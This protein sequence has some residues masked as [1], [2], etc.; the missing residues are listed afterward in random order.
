MKQTSWYPQTVL[1]LALVLISASVVAQVKT[2]VTPRTISQVKTISPVNRTLAGTYYK[3]LS[4]FVK[5]V[6]KTTLANA[7]QS[8]S[9]S[10]VSLIRGGTGGS[11]PPQTSVSSPVK[12]GDYSCVTRNVNA[13]IDYQALPVYNQTEFIFPGALLDATR[14]INNQ[15]GFYIP[16][17][18]YQRQ[19][20]RISA[21]LF[22]LTGTPQN[23]TE[24]IG[25]E[26]GEDYSQASFR[27][28]QS[29]IINRNANANPPANLMLEYIEATTQEELAV[30]LGYNL[31]ASVPAELMTILTGVPVGA[32]A[33]VSA[34]ASASSFGSKSRLLLKVH[35]SF[36]SIDAS[37][38]NEDYTKFLSPA[39][40]SD[41]PN[42]VVYVS[43]VLYGSIGFVYFE[44]DKSIT[45][46]TAAVSEAVGVTGPAD[47]GSVSVNISA[48]AR[49]KFSSTVS[50]MVAVGRGLGIP[51]NSSTQLTNL[52]QLISLIGSLRNWGPNNQGVPIAYSMNF[53]KDGV[54]A[55]VSYSTQF[56]SKVCMQPELTDLKFDVELELERMD[57]SNVRDLDGTE[58]LYGSIDFRKLKAGS[59]TINTGTS[60]FSKTEANAN[61]NNFRNGSAP[62]DKRIALIKN[63]S[64]EELRNLELTVGGRLLDDEGVFGSRVFKCVECTP[65]SAEYGQRVL[66]FI[67]IT[68]TQSSINSLQNNNQFQMLRF[69]GDHFFELNF[70]ESGKAE[71]GKVKFLFKVWV[72]PHL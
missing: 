65:V 12:D 37:P 54:Q 2:T 71:D 4:K 46:L 29:R 15:L 60:L 47:Q 62:V 53:L 14:I 68:T 23:P 55:I 52:D 61:T 39:A 41:I 69:A 20:Y 63:L 48:E 32:N 16:P 3:N 6:P 13:K 17:A 59:K 25:D 31:S 1:L 72:K 51:A 70:H 7:S 21:N 27:N 24:I 56:Q 28:A 11:T 33:N 9:R 64:F 34:S 18:S 38:T 67:E 66:K 57:V 43:S 26:A 8:T 40:G 30:K 35:Y 50:K 49:A 44:S 42:N 19:P 36:Y 45:E 5:N 10:T 22:T 58:D